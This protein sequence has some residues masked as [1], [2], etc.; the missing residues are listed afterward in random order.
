MSAKQANQVRTRCRAILDGCGFTFTRDLS[1]A[2]LQ[3]FLAELRN[4]GKPMA[5]LDPA[6][7][8]YTKAELAKLLGIK[9]ASITPLVRRHG[10]EAEGN[11]KARQFPRATAEALRERLSRGMSAQTANFY[12]AAVKQLAR[13]LVRERRMIDNP[14]AHLEGGN[15]RQDRR[16]DRQT[17]SPDHLALVLETA[18]ESTST[19]RGQA[20]IDRH[21]LYLVGMTTGFR[22][23]ELASLT[24][25]SFDLESDLPTAAVASAYTKNKRPAVQPL[26]AEVVEAL[27]SYLDG[28]PADALLW[29]GTWTEKAAE[30]F[31]RDLEAAGLPYVVD[32][33]DGPLFADFHSLRHSYVGLLEQSGA[34]VKQAMQ[35]ARHSDPRLTM[36][37]YGRTQLN[38]LGTTVSRLPSLLS[39]VGPRDETKAV[40]ATGTDGRSTEKLVGQLVGAPHIRLHSDAS[41][42]TEAIESG[43]EGDCG[44]PLKTRPECTSSHPPASPCTLPPARF[45]RATYGLGNRRSIP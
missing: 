3:E 21:A 42:C 5:R 13:W 26:P 19:F 36:A 43:H 39:K 8:T 6:K 37:R 40:R 24:P 2:R 4:R 29:P 28:K 34:S 31:R 11:G 12:L 18:R 45:E 41:P 35:L 30:M 23:S 1:A 32:G 9:P 33:P 44:N 15:I 20:G 22:V 38:D 16:H 25:R 17:L 10:L 14:L 7:E 27:R